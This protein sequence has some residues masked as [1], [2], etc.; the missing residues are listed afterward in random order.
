MFIWKLY[1]LGSDRIQMYIADKFQQVS[2]SI[3]ENGLV[4]SLKEMADTSTLLVEPGRIAKHKI[5]HQPRKR[6][7]RNL[8]K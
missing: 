7:I 8:K 5:L 4:P 3:D 1:H 2:I 6:N